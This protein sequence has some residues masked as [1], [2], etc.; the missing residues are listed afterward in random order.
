MVSIPEEMLSELDQTAKADHRSR[1]EFIREAV[2]LFLQ[3]RKSRS[4]PNQ[5]LRIR[6]AIAVQ[7][8]LAARDTAEDWDGTYEIRKWREDY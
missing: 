6:K 1:S 3:V 5:D 4:T 7:D 8:A 2:R